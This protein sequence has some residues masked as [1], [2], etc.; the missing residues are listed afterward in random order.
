MASASLHDKNVRELQKLAQQAPMQPRKP[1]AV[2]TSRGARL[3]LIDVLSRWSAPALGLIAG[4]SIYL[5]IIAGRA[6]PMRAFAWGAMVLAALWIC[7][8]L[9][10]EFRAG[11][12]LS[13]RPLRWR[14]SYTASLSVLG[15]AFASAPILLAPAGASA[16]LGLQISALSLLAV[17][18]AALLHSAH[19]YSAAALAAP[20]VLFAVLAGFRANETGLVI[21][22]ASTALL[23]AVGLRIA[24][25]YLEKSAMRQYPRTTLLR[26]EVER[27]GMASGGVESGVH[28]GAQAQ[29]A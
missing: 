16:A 12:R 13:S 21:A 3:H 10:T 17:L 25:L 8:R 9:R 27:S 19:I 6:Y 14:A 4:S 2:P 1:R 26:R 22:A 7:R 28:T 5:A 20:G 29:Q 11:A 24:N 18:I 15:V 23:A